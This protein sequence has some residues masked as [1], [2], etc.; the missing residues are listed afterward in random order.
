[1]AGEN[2]CPEGLDCETAKLSL[3]QL[4][5]RFLIIADGNCLAFKVNTVGRDITIDS[6]APSTSGTVLAGAL[7]VTFT[8]SDDFVGSIN[9]A[10]RNANMSYTFDAKGGKTPAI[11]YIITAGSITIDKIL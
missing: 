11:A 8:T 7:A 6:T 4:I 1:M 5:R 10:T 3:E 2:T 9:G